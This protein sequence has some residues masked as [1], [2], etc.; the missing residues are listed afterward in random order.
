MGIY[1][2]IYSQGALPSGPPNMLRGRSLPGL[3]EG[4]GRLS[5]SLDLGSSRG[6][7]AGWPAA[8]TCRADAEPWKSLFSIF[9]IL[10]SSLMGT[11][12]RSG[13]FISYFI[14]YFNQNF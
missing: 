8:T 7:L 13:D 9:E 11:D 3:A 12:G 2:P 5:D 14:S 1:Q 6:R 4:G 10:Y